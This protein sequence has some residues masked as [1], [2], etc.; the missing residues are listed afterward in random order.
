M[1]TF[2]LSLLALLTLGQTTQ[3][4]MPTSQP[5]LAQLETE[6][7]GSM[8]S[9]KSRFTNNSETDVSF[10]YRMKSERSGAAGKSVSSQ[11]GSVSAVAGQ[12]ITLSKTSFTLTPKDSYTI[13]LEIFDQNKVVAKDQIVFTGN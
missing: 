3:N 7:Q 4:P 2:L 11:S 13:E 12:T 6:E 1:K 9:I 10:G 8:L 5:Y